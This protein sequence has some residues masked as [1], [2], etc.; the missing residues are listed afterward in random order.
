MS[1]V[2]VGCRSE[3]KSHSQRVLPGERP[4]SSY[5][6]SRFKPHSHSF[7]AD[8]VSAPAWKWGTGGGH[9]GSHSGSL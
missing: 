6:L 7:Q 5:N 1:D 4:P 3:W 9:F 2:R 8:G